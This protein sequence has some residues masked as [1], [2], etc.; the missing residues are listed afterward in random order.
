MRFVKGESLKDAI[1]RFHAADGPGRHASERGLAL[2]HLLGQFLAVCNTV[3]YAHSRGVLHRDLKPDNILL[4]PYGETLVVDWGLAKPT[5]QPEVAGAGTDTIVDFYPSS[6][7]ATTRPGSLL[8]TPAYMSPEQ[9]SGHG[10]AVGPASDLYSLGATLYT[11]LTG[12][13]PIEGEG[14]LEVVRKVQRGEVVP[15]RQVKPAVPRALEAVCL[16]AMALRPEDR[17][18]TALELAAEV[19]HWL[20]DEPVRAYREPLPVRLRRWGR[21]HR[22][23]VTG[24]AALL[25]TAVVALAVSTSVVHRQQ[26]ETKAALQE[27]ERQRDRANTNFTLARDA[28]EK[29]ITRVAQDGRLK[30]ADFHKLRRELLA[31]AVPFYE[32][33]VRQPGADAPL[34]ADRGRAYGRLGSVRSEIGEKVQAVEAYTQMRTI[35]TRL[36]A[37]FP[38]ER[39]YR[40]E[41]AT[42]ANDLGVLLT[43]LGKRVEAEAAFRI[44][45]ENYDR[46][47]A[48]FPAV[49]DYRQ[50]LGSSHSNRGN[51]LAGLGKPEEARAAYH[52]ALEVQKPLAADFPAVPAYRQELATNSNNL[53]ALLA[54]LGQWTDAEAM[55]RAAL[56]IQ[57]PLAAEFPAVAGYRQDLA[58]S[59]YNLGILLAARRRWEEAQT[60]HQAA[61]GIRERLAADF[62]A[63]AGY[64]QDLARSHN[65]LGNLLARLEKRTEAETAYGAAMEIQKG[66]VADFPAVPVY[67][68][69]LAASFNNLGALL[70]NLSRWEEAEAAYH[71]ARGWQEQ[72]AADFPA[73]PDYAVDLAHTYGNLGNVRQESGQPE[74]SLDWYAKA[75]ARL[76]PVL[77]AEPRM[78]RARHSLRSAHRERA[79]AWTRL[80]RHAEALRDWD[81]ALELE[82]GPDRNDLRLQRALTLVQLGEHIRAAAEAEDLAQAKGLTARNFY[83]AARVHAR[84]SAAVGKD[85][86]QPPAERHAA[87]AV[88][89]LAQARAA[90][91]F[92]DR[93]NV[94][95]AKK[96]PDL[97]PLRGREDFK[98]FLGE[99]EEEAE[100]PNAR[101]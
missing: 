19:E 70:A 97:D 21:R 14:E 5:G 40:Q 78:V 52:A 99:L 81:R 57:Q 62:P 20:A 90:G 10:D 85:T 37:D 55:Y 30:Q 59:Y 48:D 43:D 86:A 15:P 9:A 35:F 72:L 75:I 1:G 61:R 60:A 68:R 67:R 2:R 38:G 39:D 23:L 88:E 74:A 50:R 42:S 77:G 27:A 46:L 73:V 17:Y 84:V 92:K 65:T 56:E 54:S 29:T 45:G 28:V 101:I 13:V 95:Q 63:V 96:D 16:K 82:P 89:L 93:A 33:F 71:A 24:A 6:T 76:E 66:L 18:G 32:E 41:L 53:G 34:E 49:P 87:R 36:T 4:G 58:R 51:L 83:D 80:G 11:L 26:Q 3:A 12:R 94:E 22:P 69:D 98:K 31:S 44:A 100:G 25:V 47:A 64:R 7:V 91:F 8:G 79:R